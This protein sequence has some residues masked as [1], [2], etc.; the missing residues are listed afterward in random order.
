[1]GLNIKTV[2]NAELF[3]VILVALFW[4]HHDLFAD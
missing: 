4:S 3:A 1:M 2:L